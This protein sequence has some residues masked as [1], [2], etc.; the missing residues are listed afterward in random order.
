[1]MSIPGVARG[2]PSPS[3][4]VDRSDD[5]ISPFLARV[6]D[7]QASGLR[8]IHGNA[9][10]LARLPVTRCSRMRNLMDSTQR[11]S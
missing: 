9:A 5:L 4:R 10:D 3:R 7:A 8:A 1:M 11:A 6:P 2:T